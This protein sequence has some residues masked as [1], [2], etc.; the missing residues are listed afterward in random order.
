[1][2]KFILAAA[3]TPLLWGCSLSP[4]ER[5]PAA[6]FSKAGQAVDAAPAVPRHIVPAWPGKEEW[7]GLQMQIGQ[8]PMDSGL[9]D[10][11]PLAA[12]LAALLG[13]DLPLFREYTRTQ[14]PL[15]Q[16]RVLFVTGN[17]PHSSGEGAAYLLIDVQSR[18]L[19]AGLLENGKLRVFANA[20]E[21][22]YQPKDVRTFIANLQGAR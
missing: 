2:R 7:S 22:L 14:A 5:S 18:R 9:F 1:M 17:K 11:P 3:C 12:P 16:D 4:E 10:E 20:G 21:P 8:Y 6:V 19:E 15:Q 13:K